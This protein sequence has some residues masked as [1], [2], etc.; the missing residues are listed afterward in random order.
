M[1]FINYTREHANEIANTGFNRDYPKS[2]IGKFDKPERFEREGW[3]YTLMDEDKVIYVGG[4]HPL[5]QGVGEVW[6]VGS[7]HL[8]KMPVKYIRAF[9][10]KSY[11]LINEHNII[12]LQAP[13]RKEF[14]TAKRFVEW[15]GLKEEGLMKKYFDNHDYYMMGW[16]R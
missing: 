1:K 16:T 14:K 12:R 9:K 7:A 13:I 4:I 15:W 10:K 11:E 6:F 3:S 2:L 8:N 5:W